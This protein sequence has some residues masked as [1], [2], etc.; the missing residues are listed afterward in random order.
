MIVDDFIEIDRFEISGRGTVVTTKLPRDFTTAEIRD[1]PGNRVRVDDRE[2]LCG[3]VD[4]HA[5]LP[6]GGVRR[7]GE[8][9]GL[10][11]RPVMKEEGA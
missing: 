5:N 11:I 4:T 9:V 7:K 10:L 8:N 1:L 6:Y 2:Y 3:G